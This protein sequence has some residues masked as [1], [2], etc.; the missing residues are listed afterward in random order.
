MENEGKKPSHALYTSNMD[1]K[2]TNSEFLGDT[3]NLLRPGTEY[4]PVESYRVVKE[5]LID[6]LPQ[7]TPRK[8]REKVGRSNDE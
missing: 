8:S 1:E 6:K 4:N 5:K 2:L 7:P 3:N